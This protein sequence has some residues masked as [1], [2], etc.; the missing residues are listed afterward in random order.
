[1]FF[2]R[3]EEARDTLREALRQ[4]D[5]HVAPIEALRLLAYQLVAEQRPY[6][7]FSTRS[8]DFIVTIQSSETLKARARAIRDELVQVVTVGLSESAGRGSADPDAHLVAGLLL[9]M[10]S[11]A[12]IE[13]HRAFRQGS[14]TEQ[15]EAIFLALIDKGTIGL[16]AAMAGTSY[17]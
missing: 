15:A 5:D 8:Q 6:V 7:E 12:F 13:G 17:A 9:A 11:V 16:K 14:N 1:M 3:D 2:D 4:R 10:W